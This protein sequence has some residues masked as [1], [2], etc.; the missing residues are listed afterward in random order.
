MFNDEFTDYFY[1]TKLMHF[2][3]ANKKPKW[4][5][6]AYRWILEKVFK[7]HVVEGV[8]ICTDYA[9]ENPAYTLYSKDKENKVYIHDIKQ[10]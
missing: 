3:Q 1:D 4:F 2:V 6:K 7:K 8:F 5:W 10:N 9:C